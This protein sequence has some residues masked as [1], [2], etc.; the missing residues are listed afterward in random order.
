LLLSA[1]IGFAAGLGKEQILDQKSSRQDMR[2]NLTGI[3][4]AALTF[5]L[6]KF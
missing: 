4:S 2:S 5:A 6:V 3:S 1:L